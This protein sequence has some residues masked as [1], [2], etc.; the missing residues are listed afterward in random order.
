MAATSTI[1]VVFVG[2]SEPVELGLVQSLAR[3]G[4]NLTGLTMYSHT[5]SAKRLEF[6]HELLPQAWTVAVLVNPANPSARQEIGDLRDASDN[7]P[8]SA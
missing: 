5:F 3:P 6:L 7:V 2:A 1:P 8:G 4:G